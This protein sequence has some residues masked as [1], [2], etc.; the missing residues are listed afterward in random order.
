MAR[1]RDV[2]I[3]GG[4]P[5]GLAAA[6]ALHKR[7]ITDVVVIDRESVLGGVPR[8]C[9]H[10]VFGMRE[11]GRLMD[12]SDYARRLARL[13]D[14]LDVRCRTTVLR[15]E[16]GGRVLIV[17]P[18]GLEQILARAVLLA[19]GAR[20]T[21]R[22]AR[23][24]S[25][26]RPWGVMTTGA[27]QQFVYLERLR[28]CERAVIVGSELVSFSA[29]LTMRHA[30][31]RPVALVEEG[32]AVVAPSPVELVARALF[33]ARV[34]TNTSVREILGSERVE[35]LAVEHAGRRLEL[36]CDGIVFTG[37]FTPEATLA[38]ASGLE[39][40]PRTL[41]P[42]VD[43]D[44]RCSWPEVFCSG[45]GLR[46]VETAGWCFRE[47]ETVA[48]KIATCLAGELPAPN[49][50][51]PVSAEGALRYVYPQRVSCTA[52]GQIRFFARAARAVRGTLSVQADG[53][54]ISRR[55]IRVLPE[56]R[57]EISLPLSS[58]RGA[59]ALTVGLLET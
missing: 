2:V 31:I 7:A 51:T 9:G 25:G 38:R 24:V 28:P 3:V 46:G 47:G 50:F 10:P 4:G 16:P 13:A 54:D 27:L 56:R 29:L 44:S 12:G 37:K 26:T 15:L 43:Q 11:F 34:M 35:G 5:S 40:D 48:E 19:A 17:G 8:H 59:K 49:E 33:G 21:P 42:I 53:Q 58:F 22:P 57:V 39:L 18:S 20:E 41:G 30:G 45:N 52:Y 32:P 23:L 36:D 1:I 55:R 6:H 14:G